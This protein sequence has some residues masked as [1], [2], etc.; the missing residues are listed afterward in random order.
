MASPPSLRIS[1]ETR[2][3]PIDVFF[4]VAL[5]LLLIVL[6]SVV[7]GSP[8]F[9]TLYMKN[10]A[11]AAEYC[12]IVR[13]KRIALFYRVCNDP[14]VTVLDGGNI[15]PISFKPFYVFVEINSAFTLFA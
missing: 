14:S 9:F 12:R 2:S 15:L 5:I 1:P 13:V 7:N 4:P 6:I 3:G 11:L 10:I 8:V